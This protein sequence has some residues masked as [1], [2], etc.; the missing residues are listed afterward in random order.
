MIYRKVGEKLGAIQIIFPN[1]PPLPKVVPV[2][3]VCLDY[4]KHGDLVQRGEDYYVRID[5]HDDSDHIAES[6]A[7]L[8]EKEDGVLVIPKEA[9]RGID[10]PIEFY[11]S[12]REDFIVELDT[13]CHYEICVMIFGESAAMSLNGKTVLVSMKGV[14]VL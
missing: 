13:Q 7:V 9:T 4:R 5:P 14:K 3:E 1:Y 11:L 12:G 8:L 2:R 10:D 6:K